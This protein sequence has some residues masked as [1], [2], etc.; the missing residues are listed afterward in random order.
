M[1]MSYIVKD[2]ELKLLA[3]FRDDWSKQSVSNATSQNYAN[4]EPCLNMPEQDDLGH[5]A[6]DH[7]PIRTSTW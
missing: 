3:K 6:E 4:Y 5:A 7:N 2:T 1:N